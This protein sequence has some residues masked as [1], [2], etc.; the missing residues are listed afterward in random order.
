M[1]LPLSFSSFEGY[2]LTTVIFKR[3]AKCCHTLPIH[4][5]NAHCLLSHPRLHLFISFCGHL[6][7][8]TLIFFRGRFPSNKLVTQVISTCLHHRRG[9]NAGTAFCVPVIR[10]YII[11][12]MRHFISSIL[13]REFCISIHFTILHNVY[14]V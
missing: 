14:L 1:S 7:E 9:K 4:Y 12:I 6:F 8:E 13:A 5:E 10:I 2:F 11:V 3:H